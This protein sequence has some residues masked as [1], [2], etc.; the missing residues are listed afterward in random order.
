MKIEKNDAALQHWTCL[1]SSTVHTCYN[2]VPNTKVTV[3]T[4]D[5][6]AVGP[7]LQAFFFHICV[8]IFYDPMYT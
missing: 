1:L 7:M 6:D 2:L 8:D 4:T 3:K 5:S